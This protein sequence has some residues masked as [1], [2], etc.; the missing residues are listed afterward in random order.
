L[1]WT[2]NSSLK[3]FKTWFFYLRFWIQI[4]KIQPCNI[5]DWLNKK[6]VINWVKNVRFTRQKLSIIENDF[7]SWLILFSLSKGLLPVT[8]RYYIFVNYKILRPTEVNSLKIAII[9]NNGC[10][11]SAVTNYLKTVS[12]SAVN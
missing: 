10:Q 12:N 6:T 4:R 2:V 11:C 1:L 8:K 9:S 3:F 5:Q 7:L